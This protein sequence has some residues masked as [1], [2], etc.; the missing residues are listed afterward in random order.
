M[1]RFSDPTFFLCS[2]ISQ[3]IVINYVKNTKALSMDIRICTKLFIWYGFFCIFF[4]GNVYDMGTLFVVARKR[5]VLYFFIL[6][7]ICRI[8][9]PTNKISVY[10]FIVFNAVTS[11]YISRITK[12]LKLEIERWVDSWPKQSYSQMPSVCS[13]HLWQEKDQHLGDNRSFFSLGIQKA[14]KLAPL[15]EKL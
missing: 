15:F 6:S 4:L 11:N 9:F 7:Y 10:D 1:I 13:S 14:S 5:I 12:E 3:N 8:K 2:R